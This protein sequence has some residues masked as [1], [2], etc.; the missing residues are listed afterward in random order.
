MA[1]STEQ[2]RT[3][4][5]WDGAMG[6]ELAHQDGL[7]GDLTAEALNL[8]APDVVRAVHHS[9]VAAGADILQTNTYQATRVALA[10]QHL[11]VEEINAT[12]VRH[13][14]SVADS[15]ASRRVWVAGSLG[16]LGDKRYAFDILSDRQMEQIYVE[17]IRALAAAGV[18]LLVAETM[19]DYREA[20]AV[21]KA[22]RQ[23]AP[24][25]PLVVQLEVVDGQT[26]G[27]RI[28]LGTV[29]RW[30]ESVGI[31]AIG[32]NC[33]VGP[34]V[35]RRTAHRLL[36]VTDLPISLQPNAGTVGIDY[37]GRMHAFGDPDDFAGFA[38]WAVSE[39]ITLVG[40][41]CHS[42]PRHTAAMR[43]ALDRTPL[44]TRTRR[45]RR[46]RSRLE[47]R[48]RNGEFVICVEI[49]PPTDDEYQL[50]PGVLQQKID[51]A[52]YLEQHYGVDVITIADHTMGKPWLDP[53]PFAEVMRPHLHHAD[54]LL[55]YS[56]RNKAETDITGNFASFKLYGYRNILIVTGDPP[57]N[58]E[59]ESFFRFSST[60]LLKRISQ[61]HP[62]S[63]FLAC[64]FDH[65][66]GMH[67]GERG[68]DGEVRRLQRKIEGGARFALTQ[69]V[70]L[71]RINLL[72]E[73]VKDLAIP[74]LPGIMPI[75]SVRHAEV[76]S[77][78]GGIVVPEYVIERLQ[79]AGDDR[80][81]KTEAA[82]EV[83]G[84]IA[85]RAQE[86]GFPGVYIISSFNRF[87][88]IAGLIARMKV[89]EKEL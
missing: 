86:L 12:A 52:R 41:C 17:Q 83:A 44:A 36:E 57:A 3:P 49:D 82:I 21:A 68:I 48:L 2:F 42:T 78:F 67:R 64:A 43:E 6:T 40:S 50:N 38:S 51:G 65:T 71:D 16:P 7:D 59:D 53:F 37:T 47:S 62:D 70:F 75:F 18:D 66:R 14:R 84:D 88:V 63:F 79:E 30:L 22:A 26:L 5:L 60:K 9:Y 19:G 56:C 45:P 11:S 76:V 29:V 69:P 55:H 39:G 15:A 58:P 35:M 85:H 72:H 28:D 10:P 27:G 87:D 1:F 61:E 20:M 77:Q 24:D 46:S 31:G 80:D 81:K 33:R 89:D 74:I 73:K 8:V 34:D 32:A 4:L 54:L 13:A 23:V 25:L